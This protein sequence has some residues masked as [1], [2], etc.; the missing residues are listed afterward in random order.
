MANLNDLNDKIA[1]GVV[2]GYKKIEDGVVDGYKKIEEGAV[3]GFEK[4]EDFFVDKLFKKED[5]TVEEKGRTVKN[6]GCEKVNFSQPFLR[7]LIIIFIRKG[8]QYI[9]GK[10]MIQASF[11]GTVFP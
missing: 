10:S 8:E 5:E 7:L 6:G 11:G 1:K 3:K 9:G 4:V 2:E